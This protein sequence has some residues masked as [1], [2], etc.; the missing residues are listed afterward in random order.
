MTDKYKRKTTQ[1]QWRNLLQN[2]GIG[3]WSISNNENFH[4]GALFVILIT[5][6]APDIPSGRTWT[7]LCR[8]RSASFSLHWSCSERGSVG[9]AAE[10]LLSSPSLQ[11]FVCLLFIELRHDTLIQRNKKKSKIIL[12]RSTRLRKVGMLTVYV[13]CVSKALFIGSSG[14]KTGVRL[15]MRLRPSSSY[16]ASSYSK[17]LIFTLISQSV[18]HRVYQVRFI[19]CTHFLVLLMKFVSHTFVSLRRIRTKPRYSPSV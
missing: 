11:F 14:I 7:S 5:Q 9:R 16:N 6:Y 1:N 8:L 2:V 3:A 13:F 15:I 18:I 17:C 4:S 19:T 12:P 10:N